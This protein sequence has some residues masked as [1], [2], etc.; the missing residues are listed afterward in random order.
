MT[1]HQSHLSWLQ[2]KWPNYPIMY[3]ESRMGYMY[4]VNYYPKATNFCMGFIYV[5][6][7]NQVLVA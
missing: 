3:F 7:A 4:T 6:Y 1:V 5:D 2:L